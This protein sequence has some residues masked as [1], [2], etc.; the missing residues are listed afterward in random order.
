MTK[1]KQTIN[2]LTAENDRLRRE[3]NR[4]T[5]LLE[6]KNR[7]S[8]K[9]V[10]FLIKLMR[11]CKRAVSFDHTYNMQPSAFKKEVDALISEALPYLDINDKM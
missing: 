11:I 8:D 3:V 4:L 9:Y 10:R 7:V 5:E 2:E 6:M 1:P